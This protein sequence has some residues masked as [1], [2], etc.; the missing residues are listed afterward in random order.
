MK[1]K[2]IETLVT[3]LTMLIEAL[4]ACSTL[5][6]LAQK[7]Q[8]CAGVYEVS[9]SRDCVDNKI[10]E[11]LDIFFKNHDSYISVIADS[12]LFTLEVVPDCTQDYEGERLLSFPREDE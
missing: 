7:A 1:R 3:N 9:Y 11:Y 5:E 6:T 4:P 12:V 8:E 2:E 10:T